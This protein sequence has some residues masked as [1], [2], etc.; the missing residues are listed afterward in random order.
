MAN[1]KKCDICGRFYNPYNN[2]S[3]NKRY[4]NRVHFVREATF[5]GS[6]YVTKAYDCCPDC[7][8]QIG[9]LV[10][11]LRNPGK[12]ETDFMKREFNLPLEEAKDEHN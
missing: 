3:M 11:D 2:H 10:Y 6:A 1:A 5:D 8:Y 12:D 7:L 4:P 9:A